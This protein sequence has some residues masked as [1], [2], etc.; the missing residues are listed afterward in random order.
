MVWFKPGFY[1]TYITSKSND[2]LPDYAITFS[3]GLPIEVHTL[4][5]QAVEGIFFGGY[6]EL[7]DQIKQIAEFW[8][9]F[10]FLKKFK[11]TG[12]KYT[13]AINKE[14]GV[15]NHETTRTYK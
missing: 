3:S 13:E 8:L 7:S 6:M 10:E 12:S 5:N 1:L 4:D 15:S 9:S 11:E 2:I 14:Q